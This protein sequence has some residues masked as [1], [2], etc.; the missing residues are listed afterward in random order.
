MLGDMNRTIFSPPYSLFIILALFIAVSSNTAFSA[1]CNGYA[2]TDTVP[3]G[4]GAAF[5]VLS[6]ARE[7]L[8]SVSCD[9]TSA[10]VSFGGGKQTQYIYE[11]GYEYVGGSWK[12]INLTGSNKVSNWYVGTATRR[13]T[14]TNSEMKDDNYVIG[15][16]CSWTGSAWK[17]GCRDS[18]CTQNLWQL[19]SFSYDNTPNQNTLGTPFVMK[20][21][22]STTVD[23]LTIEFMDVT[24]DS[25][26][27]IDVTCIWAGTIGVRLS[28]TH[29]GTTEAVEF[30]QVDGAYSFKDYLIE[31]VSTSPAPIST[32]SIASSQYEVTFKVDKGGQTL[33]V[34]KLKYAIEAKLGE[35]VYC[36]PPV[37]PAN[38]DAQLLA[39][40]PTVSANTS[41]YQAI[42]SHLGINGQSLTDQQKI[43]IVK[44][45]NRLAVITLTQKGSS[46]E[47]SL[48]TRDPA[49]NEFIQTGTVTTNG[50]VT[51]TNKTAY[52]GGCPICLA[53]GTLIDTP[54]GSVAVENVTEGMVVWSIEANG[55]RVAAPVIQIAKTPVSTHHV[56]HIVLSDG[57]EVFVSPGHPTADGRMVESLV[58][59]D[60]LDGARVESTTI[61][62]Y[63]GSF[64]YD[65]LP[66]TVSGA[67][68][69]NDIL[70]GST[71][72]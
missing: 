54:S 31:I 36:G 46:Y 14:R 56:V 59:G 28:L 2:S 71:L 6:S 63:T 12:A 45:H 15:Y 1:S 5:D 60:M 64:T 53:K 72:R 55:D 7:L 62:S 41:E 8:V 23:G 21:G 67:Y 3:N 39:Q 18:A 44:E 24:Q 17:C 33:S 50:A 13:V 34:P 43:D 65:I 52:F 25:R 20:V 27:P 51:V 49:D 35:A 26:C 11:K 58:V 32:G 9:A 68:Y 57:R 30:Q 37:V 66:D 69:A 61:E 22:E 47:F 19:Q 40:F 48:R 4:F 29:S 16:V 70:M 38:Y 42:L 10:T